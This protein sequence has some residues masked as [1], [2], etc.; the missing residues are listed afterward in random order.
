M[1]EATKLMAIIGLGVKCGQSVEVE[2]SSINE[3]ITC[4]ALKKL[5]KENL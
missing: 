3:D 5:F 1:A 2:I 4:E